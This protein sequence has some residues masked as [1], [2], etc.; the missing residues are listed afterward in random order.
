MTEENNLQP[1]PAVLRMTI[2]I[3]RKSTGLTETYELV[4]D[5]V[6]VEEATQL[7]ATPEQP[8]EA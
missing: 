6:T 4:S 8:K 2:G 1:Q 3:T 7:G 5:P